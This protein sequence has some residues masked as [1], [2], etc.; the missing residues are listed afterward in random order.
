M[1]EYHPNDL[2]L[3]FGG[4]FQLSAGIPDPTDI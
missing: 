1:D 4:A 2:C 3:G